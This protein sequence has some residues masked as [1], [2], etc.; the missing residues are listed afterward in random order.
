[1]IRR[2]LTVFLTV[3][4][5]FVSGCWDSVE[6][7]DQCYLLALAIDLT[8]TGGLQMTAS[9]PS[10]DSEK[11]TATP[12]ERK[13]SMTTVTGRNIAEAID[14]LIGSVPRNI[15]LSQLKV[16]FLSEEL[17]RAPFFL[18]VLDDLL[19]Y[20]GLRRMASVVICEGEASAFIETLQAVAGLQLSKSLEIAISA[21]N[22]SSY[23]THTRLLELNMQMHRIHGTGLAAIGAV[24]GEYEQAETVRNPVEGDVQPGDYDASELPHRGVSPTELFGT[25][26]FDAGHMVGRLSGYETQLLLFLRGEGRYNLIAVPTDEE[27]MDRTNIILRAQHRPKIS[28]RDR[29]GMAAIHIDIPL[30]ATLTQT[31]DSAGMDM[32]ALRQRAEAIATRDMERLLRKLQEQCLDPIGF[33][34]IIAREFLIIQDWEAYP[35]AEAYQNG[36]ITLNVRVYLQQPSREPGGLPL[37]LH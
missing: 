11:D 8:D 31:Y 25:A 37:E 15:N 2:C 12:E 13:R 14:V 10:V 3:S 19:S 26:L 9:I 6:I 28:V 4:L 32:E 17:A 29:G 36:E 27:D 21:Y 20:R 24:T 16:L 18:Q 23:L 34:G 35:W 5:V 7:D 33:S 22:E 1:M 30:R